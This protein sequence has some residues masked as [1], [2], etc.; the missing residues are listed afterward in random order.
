MDIRLKRGL[1]AV[2]NV[3]ALSGV[4]FVLMRLNTCAAQLDLK[5]LG[6]AN[7]LTLTALALSY[8]LSNLML[9]RAWWE[10]LGFQ[11]ARPSWPKAI[12]IYGLSQLAKYVP[13]NILHLAGRQSI[14]LASGIPGWALAR[15]IVWE[16]GLLV[17]TGSLFVILVAPLVLTSVST[18][19]ATIAFVLTLLAVS[20]L[21]RRCLAAALAKAMLWQTAFLVSSGLVF[22]ATLTVASPQV[23]P[24]IILPTWCAAYVVAWLTGLVTPGAPAGMGVRELVLVLL[25]GARVSEPELLLAVVLGRLVTIV[26]DLSFFV[27]AVAL[28]RTRT[29]IGYQNAS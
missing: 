5:R 24:L 4:A 20:L 3:L 19:G 8:G 25:L 18:S 29:S 6:V 11:R 7:A 16:L 13:G 23:T 28:A 17:G 12:C 27:L 9:A 1:F 21:E 15:S 26:G 14:G 10:L 22:L 2:G